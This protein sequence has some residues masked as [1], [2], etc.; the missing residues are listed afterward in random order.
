M[1]IYAT[2]EK[3]EYT[4]HPEG[5]YPAVAVDVVDLGMSHSM[6]VEAVK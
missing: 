4:V 5:L 3:K 1:A 2:Y 6:A